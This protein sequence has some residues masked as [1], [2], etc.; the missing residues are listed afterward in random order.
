MKA[1]L[2]ETIYRLISF[3]SFVLELF[4]KIV[5]NHWHYQIAKILVIITTPV[6]Q[7]LHIINRPVGYYSH[8][9]TVWADSASY[10]IDFRICYI[11]R[12]RLASNHYETGGYAMSITCWDFFMPNIS[13]TL[14]IVSL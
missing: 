10:L 2:K 9:P 11:V 4:T 8:L 5:I 13:L 14:I 3:I 7:C 1:L 6:Y 12:I